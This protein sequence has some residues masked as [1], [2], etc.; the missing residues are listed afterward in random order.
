MLILP[1]AEIRCCQL[2]RFHQTDDSWC[3]ATSSPPKTQALHVS[4]SSAYRR[5][6]AIVLGKMS[7]MHLLC[8]R[9]FHVVSFLV[10]SVW[11]LSVPTNSETH[12]G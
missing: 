10:V 6:D 11:Y 1:L 5:P 4:G 12:S 3:R 8:Q 7:T 9:V 2:A